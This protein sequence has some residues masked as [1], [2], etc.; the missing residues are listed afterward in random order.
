MT[1]LLSNLL[2]NSRLKCARKCLR[3]HE[4][5]YGMG[6]RPVDDPEELIFGDLVH[7]GLEAWWLGV[8]AELPQESWYERAIGAMREVADVDPFSLVRAEAMIAGYHAKWADASAEYEVLGVEERFE[9]ALCNPA[10]G[11]KSPVWRV[12]G[13]LDVRVRRR[14]DGV[15]GFIE[16][17][18][19]GEDVGPG[20]TYWARLKMDSQV[21]T[22][23]DGATSLGYE[24]QFCLYDVLAK[25]GQRPLKATPL[26]S[27]KYVVKTGLLY[28]NQRDTDETPE[29][30][31]VRCMEAI[32]KDP[33]RYYV[34][35]EVVRLEKELDAAR[36]EMW[37]QAAQ[38][39]ENHNADRHPRNPDACNAMGRTCPFF[40][41]CAGEGS[42]ENQ[43][44]FSRTSDVHPELA[45][46]PTNAASPKEEGSA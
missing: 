38:L 32:V 28:A 16:H 20:T 14:R 17:K 26:E 34:R 33:D 46:H 19:S 31:G 3:L 24:T 15:E 23:F 13:K 8:K 21:S 7:K 43:T 12:G 37:Q 36:W 6:F 9:F 44:M 5:T 4:I 1:T 42:L 18:T 2:T 45:G 40:A 27:R 30:F 41:V 39:R 10:T 35:G 22:Y 11:G 25:P 29:E